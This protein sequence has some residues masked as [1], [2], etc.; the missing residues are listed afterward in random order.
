VWSTASDLLRWGSALNDGALAVT[1]QLQTAGTL[2]GG[3][4]LGYAWGLGVRDHAGQAVYRHGGGWP[5]IRLLLARVP[6][7]GRTVLVIALASDDRHI[8]L[9]DAL[10]GL[11]T[12]R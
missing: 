10:L 6:A 8:P 12:S 9:L 2:D 4:P 7:R 11:T 5:G 1:R 3:Q